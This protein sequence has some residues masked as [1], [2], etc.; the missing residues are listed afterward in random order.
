MDK[1]MDNYHKHLNNLYI[2]LFTKTNSKINVW[3]HASHNITT[4]KFKNIMVDV[5]SLLCLHIICKVQR[6]QNNIYN[7]WFKFLFPTY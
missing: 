3:I 7:R 6:I 2:V 1:H 5:Y 4:I